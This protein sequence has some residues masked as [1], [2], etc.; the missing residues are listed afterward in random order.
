MMSWDYQVPVRI[1]DVTVIPG[2]YLVG[3]LHGILVIPAHIVEDVL[4]DA[5]LPQRA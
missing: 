4:A 3:A 5:E 2:D 1:G